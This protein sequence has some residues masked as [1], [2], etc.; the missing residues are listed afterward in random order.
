[1]TGQHSGHTFIRGNQEVLPEG[2]YPIVDSVL[3]MAEHLKD[4]GY[5]TGAFGKWG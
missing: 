4:A 5:V 1:M 2:Q 3:T